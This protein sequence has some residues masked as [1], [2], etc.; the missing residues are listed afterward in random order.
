MKTNTNDFAGLIRRP[1]E[2]TSALEDR[3]IGPSQTEI[4]RKKNFFRK[5]KLK[6]CGTILEDMAY[7]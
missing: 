1:D 3:T 2:K 7:A 5:T 4:Q 6:K